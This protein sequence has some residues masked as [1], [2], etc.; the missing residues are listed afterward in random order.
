MLEAITSIDTRIFLAINGAHT[1]FLDF[2]LFWVSNKVIWL[3]FYAFL[4]YLLALHYKKQAWVLIT[5][6]VL[7][8]VMSDQTSVHFFKDIIHRLRP[9]HNPAIMALVR[10]PDGHCGGEYGFVSSHA[11][12]SFGLAVYVGYF[13]NRKIRRFMIVLLV[14][15]VLICYS[16]VYMGVHYPLDVLIGAAWGS[17]LAAGMVRWGASLIKN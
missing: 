8:V 6:A 5:L 9:C 12:N 1:D 10:L 15:A 17:L 2:T 11:A 4:V 3:P 14:W 16:R 7:L 13:L